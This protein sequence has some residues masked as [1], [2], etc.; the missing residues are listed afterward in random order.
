MAI[1]SMQSGPEMQ[2]AIKYNTLFTAEEMDHRIVPSAFFVIENICPKEKKEEM[3]WTQEQ[4][5]M[6]HMRIR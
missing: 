1:Q 4:L 5:H 3:G 6:R 2:E